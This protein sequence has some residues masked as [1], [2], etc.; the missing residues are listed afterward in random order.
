MIETSG[1][2]LTCFVIGFVV[3]QLQDLPLSKVKNILII[4]HNKCYEQKQSLKKLTSVIATYNN[5]V[6]WLTLIAKGGIVLSQRLCCLQFLF[7]LAL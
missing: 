5:S 7:N 1:F 4:L 6:N 3:E 2:V